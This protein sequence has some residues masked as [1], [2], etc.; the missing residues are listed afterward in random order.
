MLAEESSDTSPGDASSS[1]LL[2]AA[3]ESQLFRQMNF[4]KF[5]A[6]KLR[7]AIDPRR[8]HRGRVE[9]AEQYVAAA[10]SIRDRL[11]CANLRLVISIA[12]RYVDLCTTLDE[13]VSDGNLTLMH[14][15]DKFDA[16][17]GFRFSTYATHAVQRCFFARLRKA[18]KGLRLTQG[19]EDL[20]DQLPDRGDEDGDDQEDRQRLA[21][22][23]QLLND[24]LDD[25]ER[26]VVA[27]RFGI[28]EQG[29]PQTLRSLAQRLKLSKERV[30]QLQMRALEKLIA[31][32][33]AV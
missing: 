33:Q 22:L 28:N 23:E 10:R 1:R 12:R 9:L 16:G 8:P 7:G 21:Q 13:L 2:T 3:E 32:A 11:I 4:C 30:R 6:H 20:I 25:R 5:Q 24:R 14:A 31:P 15:V 26:R 29:G 27:A 19:P 17:R 18:K